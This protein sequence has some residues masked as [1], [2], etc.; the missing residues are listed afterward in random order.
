MSIL[1]KL[2]E[3]PRLTNAEYHAGDGIS[4]SMLDVV[5]QSPAH[6]NHKYLRGKNQDHR[7]LEYVYDT[8]SSAIVSDNWIDFCKQYAEL[9]YQFVAGQK[10]NFL[11]RFSIAA[12]LL[13]ISPYSVYKY[14]EENNTKITTNCIDWVYKNYTNSFGLWENKINGSHVSISTALEFGSMVH[15]YVLEFDTFFYEYCRVPANAPKPPTAAQINAKKPSDDTLVSI[16]WWADFRKENAGKKPVTDKEL[17]QLHAIRASILS[18][19]TARKLLENG[20]AESSVYFTEPE[21]ETPCRVRPDWYSSRDFIVDLKTTASAAPRAFG[22]SAAKYR[23]HV[24]AALYMD[25]FYHSFGEYPAGFVFIAVEKEPPYVCACYLATPAMLDAGGNA[26]LQDL[27][28][29]KECQQSGEW[30]AFGDGLLD[31]RFPNYKI[32]D[33]N[34]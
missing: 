23:Y 32:S 34:E 31:L 2:T 20:I 18:N 13:G 25:A 6:Y 8:R 22:F 1:S 28:R 12:N 26:Y 9:E 4:K 19:K 27:R 17:G 24:Q 15:S 29:I 33:E 30:P 21:T 14:A 16:K 10:H 3:L 7:A 5:R 11:V